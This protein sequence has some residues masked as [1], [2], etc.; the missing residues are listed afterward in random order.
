MSGSSG[1]EKEVI[2]KW[3]IRI[4]YL[5]IF[6]VLMVS[7]GYWDRP[8]TFGFVGGIVILAFTGILFAQVEEPTL[9]NNKKRV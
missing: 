5:N 8:F 9:N 2:Q 4:L 1:L 7:V 6:I 3:I